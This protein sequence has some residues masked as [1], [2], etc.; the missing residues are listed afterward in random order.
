MPRDSTRKKS[1]RNTEIS[2][3]LTIRTLNVNGPHSPI[4]IHGL[5]ECIKKARYNTGCQQ[6]THIT[7]KETQKLDVKCQKKMHQTCGNRK[8]AGAVIVI[9]RQRRF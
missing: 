2:K 5:S 3:Y 4:K 7:T 6:E 8:Q 1:D 9:N